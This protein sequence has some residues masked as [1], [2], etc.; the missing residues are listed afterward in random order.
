MIGGGLPGAPA[1][2][3]HLQILR[4]RGTQHPPHDIAACT[5]LCGRHDA[6]VLT[7]MEMP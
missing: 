6:T 4:I 5:R 7:D 1:A 2:T 3:A